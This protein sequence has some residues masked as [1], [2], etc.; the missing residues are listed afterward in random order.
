M[1]KL[2]QFFILFFITELVSGQK[3]NNDTI[4]IEDTVLVQG[5]WTYPKNV[6][7]P[8]SSGS[9]LA[10]YCDYKKSFGFR[11]DFGFS[12]YIY[13]KSVSDWIG[14]HFGTNLNF[15]ICFKKLNIGAR[16]KPW[17]TN[18]QTELKIDNKILPKSAEINPIKYDYFISY[19]IDLN[20]YISIE[21]SIGWT[22]C[23]FE[24]INSDKINQYYTF[25]STNG[26]LTGITIN[27]YIS[28]NNFKYFV[29][30]GR[31][32]HGFVDYSKIHSSL[33]NGYTELAIGISYKFYLKDRVY[34]KIL[35][36]GN[37]E[38]R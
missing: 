24:V 35:N 29:L 33:H 21:P 37:F 27:K 13:S 28:F 18:P 25:N 23:T 26:I 8:D 16:F 1:K 10:S 30:Y 32:N 9:F 15:M 31:I 4:C 20:K 11:F 5:I 3:I 7:L 12:Q 19:E 14:N 6:Q 2:T 34:N 22:N 38:K 17:T 36:N